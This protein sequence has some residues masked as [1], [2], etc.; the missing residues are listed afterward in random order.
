MAGVQIPAW[1]YELS[2][3]DQ[4][5]IWPYLQQN[6][7]LPAGPIGGSQ[8][9]YAQQYQGYPTPAATTT[10]APTTPAGYVPSGGVAPTAT[11]AAAQNATARAKTSQL[12]YGAMRGLPYISQEYLAA[13]QGGQAPAPRT[14]TPKT[15]A[16]LAGD[17]FLS[18]SFFALLEAAGL[19]PSSFLSEVGRF[20]PRGSNVSPSFI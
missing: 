14:M 16:A 9:Q 19:Y 7:P 1:Y 12:L 11:G 17:E 18:S 20:Q 3:Q 5:F 2:P 6:L 4:A 10:P 15:L 8:W 13:L